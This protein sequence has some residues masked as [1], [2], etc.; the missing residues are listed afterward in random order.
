[1]PLN[2]ESRGKQISESLKLASQASKDYTVRPCLKMN[3]EAKGEDNLE[4][5]S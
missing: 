4:A 3:K 2:P 5:N 1:M